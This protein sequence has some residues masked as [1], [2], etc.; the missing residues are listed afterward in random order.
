[1]RERT[2]AEQVAAL[3]EEKLPAEEFL[4]RAAEPPPADEQRELL[5]LIRWF[6]QRYPT[7]RA[8][9]A[10]ARRKQREWTRVARYSER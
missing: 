9:L 7:P 3:A 6:R 10:Y 5:Q 1:M 8:R 4:R 2:K